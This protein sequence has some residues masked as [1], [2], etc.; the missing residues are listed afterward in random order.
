MMHDCNIQA[1]VALD[2][3]WNYGYND[4]SIFILEANVLGKPLSRG[5]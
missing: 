1:V 2:Q 3:K 5:A 4:L